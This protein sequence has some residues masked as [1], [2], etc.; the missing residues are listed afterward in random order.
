LNPGVNPQLNGANVEAWALQ[1]QT[2]SS[3]ASKGAR[4]M[5][6][7]LWKT[8]SK[9]SDRSTTQGRDS[10]QDSRHGGGSGLANSAVDVLTADK[11]ASQ[12]Q[13]EG[14]PIVRDSGHV[15]TTDSAIASLKDLQ[16]RR[17]LLQSNSSAN[18][19]NGNATQGNSSV[20]NPPPPEI[21]PTYPA[22]P[23]FSG[24]PASH[25]L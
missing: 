20:V 9:S 1:Q 11:V 14:E 12:I 19:S 10:A 5:P 13:E 23:F 25:Y 3:V 22:A 6:A 2:M 17:Q 15:S 21:L 18:G 4:S 24:E 7:K 8:A 16:S